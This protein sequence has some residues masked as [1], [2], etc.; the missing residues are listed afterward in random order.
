MVLILAE[1]SNSGIVFMLIL[2]ALVVGLI[3]IGVTLFLFILWVLM[4]IDAL[5]R[6]DWQN[7][8]ERIM[9]TIVLILSLFVGLWGIAAVVYYYVIKHPR[10]T[11]DTKLEEAKI[12]TSKSKN[13]SSTRPQR[14]KPHKRSSKKAS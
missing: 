2:V 5:A 10:A 12:V 11:P 9:W 6:K 14:A 13:S 8:D 3:L 7:D 4:L 1:V